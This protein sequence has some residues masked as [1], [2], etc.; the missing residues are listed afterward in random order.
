MIIKGM[1]QVDRS[2]IEDA[3]PP[4]IISVIAAPPAEFAERHYA[5]R[6]EWC[7]ADK[8][9]VSDAEMLQILGNALSE[10]G[11]IIHSLCL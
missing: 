9:I 11:G 6:E 2:F 4:E 8:E 1:H 10:S 5:C 3:T 7:K